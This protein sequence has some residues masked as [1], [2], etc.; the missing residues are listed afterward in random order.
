MEKTKKKIKKE[1]GNIYNSVENSQ[2][3][4]VK[5]DEPSLEVLKIVATG[6]TNLTELFKSQN[7]TIES[8]LSIE[9]KKSI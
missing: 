5:W 4:G 9:D 6:L 3:Y 7:V 1:T 2:F 8:L